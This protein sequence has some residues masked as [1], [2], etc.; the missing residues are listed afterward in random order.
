MKKPPLFLAAF[1]N[2]NDSWLDALSQE[3][4]RMRNTLAPLHD[5]GRIEYLSI[6]ST[7]VDD[8]YKNFNRYH[9]RIIA[10]HFA[11]HSGASLLELIDQDH[12]AANLALLMGM[13]EHLH[14]VVL[15]GC[16]NQAQVE[17]LLDAGVK[18]VI[19]TSS[20]IN[21]AWA[22][23]FSGQFYEA[24]QSGKTIEQSFKTA[25]SYLEERHQFNRAQVQMR[26]IKR[27]NDR[28]P[29]LPWGLYCASE[30]D[31]NWKLPEERFSREAIGGVPRLSG[32]SPP[33]SM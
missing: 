5:Q 21:D 13:Q 14:L 4:S 8:I 11:G 26:G 24:L 32:G 10:F 12:R 27:N 6:G 1:A 25:I 20:A 18:V 2:S 29:V 19:A 7:S 31:L 16:A 15:N 9:N 3:E 30:E 28:K 23:V 17:A 22:A 33:S